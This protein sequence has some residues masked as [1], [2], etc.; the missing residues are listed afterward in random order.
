MVFDRGLAAIKS[1][2]A[3]TSESGQTLAEYSLII[4]L[5]AIAAIIGITMVAGGVNSLWSGIRDEAEAAIDAM[6]S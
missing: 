4:A 1:L 6:L 5:I 3:R 2:T